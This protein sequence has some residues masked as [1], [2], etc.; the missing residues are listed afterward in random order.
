VGRFLQNSLAM[1]IGH[2]REAVS[3][4]LDLTQLP[5]FTASYSLYPQ[6]WQGVEALGILAEVFLTNIPVTLGFSYVL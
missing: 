2:Q 1:G 4:F 5:A 3:V 6:P